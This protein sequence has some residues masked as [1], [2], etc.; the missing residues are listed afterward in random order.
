MASHVGL[1]I[2][3]FYARAVCG[4]AEIRLPTANVIAPLSFISAA[5][6]IML[7]VELVKAGNPD[8]RQWSLDNYFRV[9]TLRQPIP[10]FRRTRPQEVSGR[11]IC[12]DPDFL[13]VHS[14][15]YGR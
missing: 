7:A 3:S 11:C 4:D 2:N 12:R 13:A 1:P 10:A 9:D 8:I 6:G 5:A 15:K 14:E